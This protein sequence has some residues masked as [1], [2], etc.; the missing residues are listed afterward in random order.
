MRF[1]LLAAG[2]F[3]LTTTAVACQPETTPNPTSTPYPTYTPPPTYTPYPTYTPPPTVE[4]ISAA[5]R[6]QLVWPTGP[7]DDVIPYEDAAAFLGETVTVEGTIVDT[8]HTGSVTFLNF[9]PNRTDFKAVI[10]A[11]DRAGFP[12]PPETLFLGKL[13]RVQGLIEEYEGGPE[14]IINSPAQIEVALTLGQAIPTECNC[15]PPEPCPAPAVAAPPTLTHTQTITAPQATEEADGPAINWHEA[16]AYAGQTVTV[17][18]QVV[19]TYNSGKVIFLNFDQD[20]R[21][22]FKVVIFPDAWTLFPA[23]PDEYYRSREIAVTG[24]IEI[25]EGAPEIII[26]HPDQIEIVE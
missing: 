14:I 26:N 11:D 3:L 7:R 25:Y 23:S 16:A 19:D 1:T 2:I 12:A 17:K 21:N 10:F 13:V 9:S 18:G 22:T 20:Y 5:E 24:Q 6:E 15:P 4:R 8:H